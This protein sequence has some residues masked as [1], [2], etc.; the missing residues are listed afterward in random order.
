[1]A[2][3]Y[4][5]QDGHQ[6]G[7]CTATRINHDHCLGN[8]ARQNNDSGVYGPIFGGKE[9]M[10]NS[11]KNYQMTNDPK[12]PSCSKFKIAANARYPSFA[13]PI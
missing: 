2:D 13:L 5:I 12:A 6:D 11:K 3:E 8:L 9:L 7:R 10:S 4:L 1:M